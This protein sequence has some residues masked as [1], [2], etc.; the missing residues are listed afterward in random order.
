[1]GFLSLFLLAS[2]PIAQVLLIGLL[3]AYLAS[4]YSNIL[5]SS[6]REDINKVVY[7]VFTPTLMFASLSQTVTLRDIISW[8]FMPVN[9]GLIFLIGSMLG[10]IVVR[11]LKIET[12]LQGLVIAA[13]SAGNLGNLLL[14]IIPAICSEAGS[15]FGDQSVCSANGLS[16]V[17]FSMALG[18]LYMW[19][20]TYGIMK[21]ARRL[22]LKL[23]TDNNGGDN[24]DN[25]DEAAVLTSTR[26][27]EE[28]TESELVCCS[29]RL[30]LKPP[31]FFVHQILGFIFGTVPWL[32]S[33][34]VGEEAPL[35]VVQDSI[36]LLGNGTIPC[37]TLILG[38]NLSKGLRK[39]T[40][41]PLMIIAVICVRYMVLPVIGIGVVKLANELGYLPED[42]LYHFVL[43]IQFT[44]PPAMNISTMAQLLHSG[45]D[46]CSVV[47]LWSY[48]VAALALTVWSMIFMWILS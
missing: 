46:E 19:T 11:L 25:I 29:F 14:I 28:S 23:Q 40:L 21:K 41:K 38:G 34:V 47:L 4:G 1:M 33:L 7:T 45:Q 24:A 12:H 10:Q 27:I 8:W 17:S 43:M 31:Y 6:A 26:P 9:V 3:G 37:I 15:P 36:K 30:N 22:Q 44:M 2:M 39:S 18:G 42:P 35:R 13:C 5:T 48:L 16:Y 20:Y 32:R